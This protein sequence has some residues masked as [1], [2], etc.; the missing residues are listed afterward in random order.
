[1][2]NLKGFLLV[3]AALLFVSA[4]QPT[5]ENETVI[6]TG[7]FLEN[8]QEVSF[9]PY[10]APQKVTYETETAEL[11]LRFDA[12]VIAPEANAYSIVQLERMQYTQEDYRRI[13]DFFCPSAEWFDMPERTK[14]EI[15]ANYWEIQNNTRI[16]EEQKAQFDYLLEDAKNAPDT[17]V[18]VPFDL[19]AHLEDEYGFTAQTHHAG[20]DPSFFSITPLSYTWSYARSQNGT[21]YQESFLDPLLEEDGYKME[22][23]K[24]TPQISREEAV[25]IAKDAIRILGFDAAIQLYSAEKGIAY[26]NQ[27][28]QAYGWQC[29]FTRQYGGVQA[30]DPFQGAWNTWKNSP[31]PSYAAPW[32]QENIVVFVDEKGLAAFSALGVSRE[33]EVLY[34]NVALL[35]FDTLLERI[36][37]QLKYQ[38]AF[39]QEGIADKACDITSIKLVGAVIAQKDEPDLGLFIPSWRVEYKLSFIERGAEVILD[40]NATYFNAIDGSYIE[41]RAMAEMLGYQ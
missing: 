37:K 11:A 2:K 40:N 3:F 9:A 8:L 14:A 31:P 10:E 5:P 6:Q 18:F 7:D 20:E 30:P 13:M 4:C 15:I 21:I 28:P 23:F 22:D 25:A 34:E 29:I 26:R 12:E 41:P 17:V 1:M 27:W 39:V 24:R 19:A 38:H 36:E 32:P 33:K 35:P 16:S